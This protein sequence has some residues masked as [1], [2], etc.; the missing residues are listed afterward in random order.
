MTQIV[1]GKSNNKYEPAVIVSKAATADFDVGGKFVNFY[2]NDL[3][4]NNDTDKCFVPFA[5]NVNSHTGVFN[6]Y[7]E[8]VYTTNLP[9]SNLTSANF[10]NFDKYRQSFNANSSF[11][12]I[13]PTTM[14][15]KNWGAY[16]IYD[17]DNNWTNLNFPNYLYWNINC[18]VIYNYLRIS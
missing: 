5:V 12:S 9:N 11:S 2:M 10:I 6:G 18:D 16:Q 8:N 3:V 1:K 15:E 13:M 14:L 4:S 17:I 7:Y